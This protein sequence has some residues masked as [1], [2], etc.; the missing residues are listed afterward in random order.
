MTNGLHDKRLTVSPYRRTKAG[1]VT[2]DP[3]SGKSSNNEH[4]ARISSRF[5]LADT[6]STRSWTKDSANRTL[7]MCRHPSLDFIKCLV[8][9]IINATGLE[10]RSTTFYGSR[11]QGIRHSFRTRF[12]DGLLEQ[13]FGAEYKSTVSILGD[14]NNLLPGNILDFALARLE[15]RG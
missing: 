5:D 11:Q 1:R 6:L 10:I 4:A 13:L 14:M 8:K 3:I 9:R 12:I 2:G 7:A 15:C